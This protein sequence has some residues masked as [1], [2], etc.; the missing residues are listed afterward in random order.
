MYTTLYD[1]HETGVSQVFFFIY[2][3]D[4]Y[5][6]SNLLSIVHFVDNTTVFISQSNP[7]HQFTIVL[8]SLKSVLMDHRYLIAIKF[9][10]NLK[11]NFSKKKKNMLMI[12]P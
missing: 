11:Y 6:S 5:N 4:L 3:N 12:P 8:T 10:L 7:D 9:I 1:T 2:L